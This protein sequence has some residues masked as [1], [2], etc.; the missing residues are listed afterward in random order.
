MCA[1]GGRKGGEWGGRWGYGQK[2]MLTKIARKDCEGYGCVRDTLG[3]AFCPPR[4]P[5]S[6]LLSLP[7]IA[8]LTLG[9]GVCRAHIRDTRRFGG[10]SLKEICL[11]LESWFS[12]A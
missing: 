7:L 11:H 5:V 8:S 9:T 12:Q 4:I 10:R 6:L 2:V 3:A 1:Q